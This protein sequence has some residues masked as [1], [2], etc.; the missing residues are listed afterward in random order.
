VLGDR[1]ERKLLRKKKEELG[2]FSAQKESFSLSAG[3]L[4]RRRINFSF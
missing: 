2:S 4:V 1:R 3:V